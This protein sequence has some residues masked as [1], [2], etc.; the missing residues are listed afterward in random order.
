M[1]YTL[2]LLCLLCMTPLLQANPIDGHNYQ[3]ARTILDQKG[4][5]QTVFTKD[6][7]NQALNGAQKELDFEAFHRIK[8]E[9]ED[10]RSGWSIKVFAE[11]KSSYLIVA[12]IGGLLTWYFQDKLP[13]SPRS[14]A[15]DDSK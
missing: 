7:L 1:R 3:R 13:K 12:A 2:H 10:K 6:E 9:L 11:E 8:I 4:S 15:S 5:L 14:K